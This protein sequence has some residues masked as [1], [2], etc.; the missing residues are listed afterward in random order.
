MAAAQR[1][2]GDRR[3]WS[4]A[5]RVQGWDVGD[6]SGVS[7][8]K[9]KAGGHRRTRASLPAAARGVYLG[10]RSRPQDEGLS[11][12][13]NTGDESVNPP[14][15]ARPRAHKAHANVVVAIAGRV[16]VAIRRPHIP[17]VIVEVAAPIDAI[18]AG[19]GSHP[20]TVGATAALAPVAVGRAN[21]GVNMRSNRSFKININDEFE[22]ISLR[23]ARGPDIPNRKIDPSRLFTCGPEG[24]LRYA[25]LS[26]PHVKRLPPKRYPAPP[27][28]TKG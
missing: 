21:A 16:V 13:T 27:N 8:V 5:E 4:V 19:F 25:P 24:L 15:R 10:R 11:G 1:G 18:R 26:G 12:A 2:G 7:S 28:P 17:G 14:L 23:P 22:K 9:H 6:T 20:K 3:C